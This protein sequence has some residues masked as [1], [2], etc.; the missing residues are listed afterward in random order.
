LDPAGRTTPGWSVGSGFPKREK[1]ISGS[2]HGNQFDDWVRPIGW[3]QCV[4][5]G[6]EGKFVCKVAPGKIRGIATEGFAFGNKKGELITWAIQTKLAG[7]LWGLTYLNVIV[8]MHPSSE[9]KQ[10][11]EEFIHGTRKEELG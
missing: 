8:G 3:I 7:V 11:E 4:D 6:R 2:G 1:G 10:G 9:D 5:L